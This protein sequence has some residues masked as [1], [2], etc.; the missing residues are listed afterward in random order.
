MAGKGGDVGNGEGEGRM[1]GGVA[2]GG[3]Q[4]I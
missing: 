2:R 1:R 3:E 4:G